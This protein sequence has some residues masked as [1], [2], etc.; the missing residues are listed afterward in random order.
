MEYTTI[1]AE[2]KEPAQALVEALLCVYLFAY[3]HKPNKSAWL[4]GGVILLSPFESEESKTQ[5]G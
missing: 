1:D 4:L 2:E 3:V 5:R